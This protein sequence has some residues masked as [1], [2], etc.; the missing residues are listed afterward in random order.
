LA[1]ALSTGNNTERTKTNTHLDVNEPLAV[2]FGL[3]D[4]MRVEGGVWLAKFVSKQTV[5]FAFV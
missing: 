4:M 5:C 2:E 1:F 3:T